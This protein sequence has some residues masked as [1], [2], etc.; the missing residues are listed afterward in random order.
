MGFS[1]GGNHPGWT[2]RVIN[3]IMSD[4]VGLYDFDKLVFVDLH[5]GIGPKGQAEAYSVCPEDSANHTQVKK[6]L[7]GVV[8]TV[9]SPYPVFGS[10]VCA[11][12]DFFS[13]KKVL[14]FA[15]ECGTESSLKVVNSLRAQNWL[16]KFGDPTQAYAPKI[17]EDIA[18]AFYPQDDEWKESVTNVTMDI[19]KRATDELTAENVSTHQKIS[20]SPNSSSI[21]FHSIFS[22]N[23]A[24]PSL[25]P[26]TSCDA[27]NIVASF[28]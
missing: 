19:F 17:K 25:N 10:L 26:T 20:T 23:K 18:R 2:N 7:A 9:S 16:D 12:L 27:N 3:R 13:H 22:L 6:L 15:V 28:N 14:G 4:I 21:G 8:N 5:T 1:Y 11:I 24:E